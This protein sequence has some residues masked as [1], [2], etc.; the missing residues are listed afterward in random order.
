MSPGWM[1]GRRPWLVCYRDRSPGRLRFAPASLRRGHDSDLAF[2]FSIET[3]LAG[4]PAGY[5]GSRKIRTV[6]R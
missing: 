2:S 4:L 1:A 6:G 3:L 5:P